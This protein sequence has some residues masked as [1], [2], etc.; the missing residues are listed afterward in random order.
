M[1][2][3][4]RDLSPAVEKLPVE[5]GDFV[6]SESGG[7][8]HE[9]LTA[10]NQHVIEPSLKHSIGIRR[11]IRIHRVGLEVLLQAMPGIRQHWIVPRQHLSA[12]STVN[13]AV[14]FSEPVGIEI[15]LSTLGPFV[16]ETPA[17]MAVW[18]AAVKFK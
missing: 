7:M 5:H 12:I 1:N 17:G 8:N 16:P 9:V 6:R 3:S 14:A 15:S 4:K 2:G 18:N 10:V 13:V 11:A